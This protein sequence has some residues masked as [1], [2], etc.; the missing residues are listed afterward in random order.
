M[1]N[2]HTNNLTHEGIH[3]I[4]AM[5]VCMCVCVCFKWHVY[6]DREEDR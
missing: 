1:L 2:A 3:H 5:L 6:N 4:S